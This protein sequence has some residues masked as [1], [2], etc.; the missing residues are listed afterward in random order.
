VR[1]V[2]QAVLDDRLHENCQG[3]HELTTPGEHFDLRNHYNP[4]FKSVDINYDDLSAFQ[5]HGIDLHW[6]NTCNFKCVYCNSQQSSL[7]AQEQGLPV[8][9]TDPDNVDKIIDLIVNNQ[10]NMKEI[11]LSGGEPLLIKH[12][13]RLLSRIDNTD[14]PLR[15]NSNI[16]MVDRDNAVFEQVQR[17]TNVLW[18]VSA[19]SMG[20]RFEY[21]R[22]GSD[23]M[24]FLNN[25]D[26]LRSL[27]HAVRINMVWFVASAPDFA[28]TVRFFIDQYAINDFTV[29]QLYG[30]KYLRVRNLA[31]PLKSKIR[32]DLADLLDS[33]KIQSKT[34]SWYNI[35]RCGRELEVEPDEQQPD[36]AAY[37][38]NLDLL[39]GTNWRQVF[40]ELS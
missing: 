12:N 10:W 32:Q 9:K 19:E 24:K 31:A 13:A 5:M 8:T 38:D 39:R 28:E 30:H 15:I 2:K 37:F 34:N 25:L 26:R 22:H 6:D 33:G 7:I 4:M 1:E 16:S 18:T 27:G 11:Y 40:P 29:N 35:E 17:F 3:C 21:M 20:A 14:L 36:Y 23:W